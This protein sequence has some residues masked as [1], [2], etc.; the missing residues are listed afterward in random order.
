MKRLHHGGVVQR[1][2]RLIPVGVVLDQLGIS[3]PGT[4]PAGSSY[5]VYC[6]FGDY[7]PDRG[8]EKE[9]RLYSDGK[10]YCHIC[11]RQYDSVALASQAWGMAYPEAAKALLVAGGFSAAPEDSEEERILKETSPEELRT[12][13]VAA[14]GVFADARDID[15][16]GDRYARCMEAADAITRPEHVE[17]WLARCKEFLLG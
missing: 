4:P 15:R 17:K 1:A 6:P 2:I 10:A 8:A 11:Q 7:H 12:G 9:M 13:A 3:Y 16:F 5:K 14:L